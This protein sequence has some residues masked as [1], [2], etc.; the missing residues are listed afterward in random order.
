MWNISVFISDLDAA[1]LFAQIKTV[2]SSTPNTPLRAS[3][4]PNFN[5]IISL[6]PSVLYGLDKHVVSRL[7]PF[8]MLE[9]A[10]LKLQWI[11]LID[12]SIRYFT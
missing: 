11:T 5:R 7:V 2:S 4:K 10:H 3:P 8:N 12:Q 6:S 1:P 9:N